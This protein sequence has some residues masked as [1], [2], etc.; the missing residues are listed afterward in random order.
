MKDFQKWTLKLHTIGGGG[1]S[2]QSFAHSIE[3]AFG[4]ISSESMLTSL[5]DLR[6][7]LRTLR[8][9]PAFTI[10]A[11]I[12]LALGVGANT[13]IFSVVKAVLLN[14]LPFREP[15]R[16]LKIAESDPDTPLRSEE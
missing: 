4:C 2:S 7:S 11:V 6:F 9:N 13:A 12:T 3:R 8:K 1:Q 5:S 14:Q 16:L 15:D 10:V